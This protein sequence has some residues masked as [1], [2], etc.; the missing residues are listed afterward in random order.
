MS[1][2]RISAELPGDTTYVSGGDWLLS[3]G[4]SSVYPT[5]ATNH[6]LRAEVYI[7]DGRN[8]YAVL[9]GHR[10]AI[11]DPLVSAAIRTPAPWRR[12]T[13]GTTSG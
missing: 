3:C 1:Q 10:D 11:A 2:L 6:S 13:A 9:L 7:N 12:S 4:L 8:Y 5:V